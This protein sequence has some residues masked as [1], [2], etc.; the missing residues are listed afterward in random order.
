MVVLI[1]MLTGVADYVALLALF[2]ANA[3]MI[4]F[5]WLMELLDPPDRARTRWLPF[6]WAVSS[7]PC[8]GSRSRCRSAFGGDAGRATGLRLFDLVSLFVLFKSFAVNQALRYSASGTA[9]LPLR[10]ALILLAEP[11]REEPP[12]LAGLRE[13]AHAL[14]PFATRCR[15]I[16]ARDNSD[17]R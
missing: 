3:A 14:R 6:V 12:R 7:A 15:S 4:F 9:R 2:A 1:A 11:R 5:G 8:R 13:R 10:R 16:C 17:G